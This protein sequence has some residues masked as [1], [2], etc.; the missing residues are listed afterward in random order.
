MVRTWNGSV[1]I[2]LAAK[3][4]SEGKHPSH[5]SLWSS[6]CIYGLFGCL[7]CSICGVGS[8]LVLCTWQASAVMAKHTPHSQTCPVYKS[9]ELHKAKNSC[10][11]DSK[12]KHKL[13]KNPEVFCAVECELY[14]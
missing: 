4:A 6:L 5:M 3:A 10:E 1:E 11:C 14:R 2:S 7:T 8:S 12:Q 13:T 9:S